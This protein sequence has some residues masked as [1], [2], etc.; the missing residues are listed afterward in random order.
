MESSLRTVC[1]CISSDN[2]LAD[3]PVV[4]HCP[5]QTSWKAHG[6]LW[7]ECLL[8]PLWPHPKPSARSLWGGFGCS[9]QAF[10]GPKSWKHYSMQE[11]RDW[12]SHWHCQE[13]TTPS[14]E[15]F[16]CCAHSHR[17]GP[18]RNRACEKWS[19]GVRMPVFGPLL[20]LPAPLHQHLSRVDK[21][22]VCG[23]DRSLLFSHHHQVLHN[24]LQGEEQE[25]DLPDLPHQRHGHRQS[26][27]Q[28]AIR[29]WSPLQQRRPSGHM[30][31]AGHSQYQHGRWATDVFFLVVMF[32]FHC[33]SWCSWK[34]TQK[35]DEPRPPERGGFPKVHDLS[36]RIVE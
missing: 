18:K 3:V 8:P 7:V 34:Y 6:R 25:V 28:H 31:Q 19:A 20:P 23:F 27:A 21:S 24:P 15:Q 29:V 13:L 11:R 33:G 14:A 4:F 12:L 5:C 26:E 17:R 10:F 9:R 22:R 1:L 35:D 16:P 2:T 32:W 30:E 36:H